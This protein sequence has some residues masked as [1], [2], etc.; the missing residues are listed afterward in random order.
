[1]DAIIR[2]SETGLV[3]AIVIFASLLYAAV[4]IV[5]NISFGFVA[6]GA[7]TNRYIFRKAVALSY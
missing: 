5:E 3:A 1:M 7:T 2:N 6:P 4:W